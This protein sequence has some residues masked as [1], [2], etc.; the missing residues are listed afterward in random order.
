MNE[1]LTKLNWSSWFLLL[2]LFEIRCFI[3]FLNS[4]IM[5]KVIDLMAKLYSETNGNSFKCVR[6][7]LNELLT[8]LNLSDWFPLLFWY[9]I[10]FF[11]FYQN[12]VGKYYVYSYIKKRVGLILWVMYKNN[13]IIFCLSPWCCLSLCWFSLF[14]GLCTYLLICAAWWVMFSIFSLLPLWLS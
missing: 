8:K 5:Y 4:H 3:F 12:L 14:Y 10:R 11:Y 2:F 6:W 13:L 7:M 9:E 1:L